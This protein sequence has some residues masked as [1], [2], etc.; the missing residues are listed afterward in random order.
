GGNRVVVLRVHDAGVVEQYVQPAELSLGGGH[1]LL[2]VAGFRYIRPE[3]GSSAAL[4]LD[5]LHSFLGCLVVDIDGKHRRAFAREEQ[6]GLAPDAAAGAGDQRNFVFESH[7]RSK[8]LL[9]SQSVTALSK[10]AASVR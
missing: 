10:A 6:R 4:L 3:V 5:E 8:Y 2:A 7:M 9:R 1:H